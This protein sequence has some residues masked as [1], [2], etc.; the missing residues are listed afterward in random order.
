MTKIKKEQKE[1]IEFIKGVLKDAKNHKAAV[2]KQRVEM[3]SQVMEQNK[4][5]DD[6]L[7]DIEHKIETLTN[8][9]KF[10]S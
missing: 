2:E 10:L 8:I 9:L 5:F 4:K 1:E 6:N 7:V 3:N